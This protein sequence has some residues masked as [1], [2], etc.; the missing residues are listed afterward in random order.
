MFRFPLEAVQLI[1]VM[2][3]NHFSE[4]INLVLTI[5]TVAGVLFAILSP[6]CDS[7]KRKISIKSIIVREL[8]LNEKIAKLAKEAKHHESIIAILR[9]LQASSWITFSEQIGTLF[10]GNVWWTPMSRH[11]RCLSKIRKG[12]FQIA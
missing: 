6:R 2:K 9:N 4:Y 12:L 5:S 7:K 8:E 11:Q 3:P 10:D 1:V